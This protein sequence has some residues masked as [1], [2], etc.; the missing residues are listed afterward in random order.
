MPFHETHLLAKVGE[1]FHLL[2]GLLL[3]AVEER[4]LNLDSASTCLIL[5]FGTLANALT[6]LSLRILIYKMEIIITALEV[7]KN[8]VI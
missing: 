3:A 2:A 7:G 4:T 1:G 8:F 5:R 6:L